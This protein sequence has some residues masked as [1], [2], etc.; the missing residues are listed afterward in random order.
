M[1][2][3]LEFRLAWA[4]SG[5]PLG[6]A[7]SSWLVGVHLHES[8]LFTLVVEVG[9]RD[10]AERRKLAGFGRKLKEWSSRLSC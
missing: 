5:A 4:T 10:K 8:M 2:A 9:R 7:V 3:L 6:W 1:W